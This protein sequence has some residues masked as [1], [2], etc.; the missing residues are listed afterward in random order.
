MKMNKTGFTLIE[1][2]IVVLIIGVLSA[3]SVPQYL[4]SVEKARATEAVTYNNAIAKAIATRFAERGD[5]INDITALPLDLAF[6]SDTK[7]VDGFKTI[8]TERFD[9]YTRAG[10][11]CSVTAVKNSPVA[12]KQYRIITTT[13]NSTAYGQRFRG[14]TACVATTNSEGSEICAQITS[15]TAITSSGEC[16]VLSAGQTCYYF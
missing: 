9:F 16:P 8:S 11:A 12:A 7:T 10:S 13:L 3:V 5:C 1:L 4:K 14:K 2:M 6:E 15:N